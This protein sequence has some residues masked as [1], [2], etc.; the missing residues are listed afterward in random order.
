MSKFLSLIQEKYTNGIDDVQFILTLTGIKIIAA[1]RTLVTKKF[2]ECDDFQKVFF[3]NQDKYR[4]EPRL[5]TWSLYK[6]K[7]DPLFSDQFVVENIYLDRRPHLLSSQHE[8]APWC[9]LL[10]STRFRDGYT[11]ERK[12]IWKIVDDSDIDL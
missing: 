1:G 10:S 8:P 12:C 3:T 4:D 5:S 2:I 11:D 6:Y 7:S 9:Q